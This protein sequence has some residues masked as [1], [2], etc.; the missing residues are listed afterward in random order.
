M[1]QQSAAFADL[2]T[3]DRPCVCGDAR[4]RGARSSDR[5]DADRLL[6]LRLC[7]QLVTLRV[8]SHTMPGTPP[9]A[10]CRLYCHSS[11]RTTV[12]RKV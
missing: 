3:C 7:V 8:Q 2:A 4:A 12:Q 6:V 5:V 11:V 1:A 10:I 9:H